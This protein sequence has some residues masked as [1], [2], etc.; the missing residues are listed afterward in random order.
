LSESYPLSPHVP[1][2]VGKRLDAIFEG[3]T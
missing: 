3:K 1:E 2:S